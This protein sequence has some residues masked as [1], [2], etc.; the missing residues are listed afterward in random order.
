MG[1]SG[2]PDLKMLLDGK[3][4]N[5]FFRKSGFML[6]FGGVQVLKAISFQ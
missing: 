2:L 4:A 1:F 6:D 3:I 5:R